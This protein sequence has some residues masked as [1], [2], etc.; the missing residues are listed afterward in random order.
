MSIE[1]KWQ[2]DEVGKSSKGETYPSD[3]QMYKQLPK[4]LVLFAYWAHCATGSLSGMSEFTAIDE[5]AK[6]ICLL[7]QS[8][9]FSLKCHYCESK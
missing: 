1:G 7:V 3:L 2:A 8:F 4:S 5:G 9:Y 6:C